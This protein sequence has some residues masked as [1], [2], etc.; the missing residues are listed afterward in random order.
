MAILAANSPLAGIRGRIE[1]VIFRSVNGRTIVSARPSVSRARLKDQSDR[2]RQTRSKFRNAARCAKIMMMDPVIKERYLRK[3]RELS[4]P[5]AYTAA[6][7]EYMQG[8]STTATGTERVAISH[9][10]NKNCT[11]TQKAGVDCYLYSKITQPVMRSLFTIPV[12]FTCIVLTTLHAYSQSCAIDRVPSSTTVPQAGGQT[13]Q[14][15][16]VRNGSCTPIF[17]VSDSWLTYT[18][19]SGF[20]R[21]TAAANP[22]PPRIGYVYVDNKESLKITINQAGS[23]VPVTGVT[24][25]PITAFLNTTELRSLTATVTPSNATNKTV[26]WTSDNSAIASVNYTTGVVTGVAAGTAVITART[27][28]ENRTATCTVTVSAMEKTFSWANRNGS[29]FTTPVKDQLTGGPCFLFAAVGAIEAKYKIV[30]NQPTS[31]IDLSEGQVNISCLGS[32]ESIP[33]AFTFSQNTG[34]VDEAC[35]PYARS[36]YGGGSSPFPNCTT[37]CANPQ[38]RI[39]ISGHTCIDFSTIA[40]NSRAD[41]LKNAIKQNGSVAVSFKSPSLHS[42]AM[43]AYEVYG[44][45]ENKWLMKDSWQ[46]QSANIQT[47]VNIPTIIATNESN[48]KACYI[49]GITSTNGRIASQAETSAEEQRFTET[50]LTLYPNPANTEITLGNFQPDNGLLELYKSDGSL[51][52]GCK[53]TGNKINITELPNG[54]YFVKV[55]QNKKIRMLKFIKL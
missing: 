29:N 49:T 50:D 25:S 37:P 53:I 43:H 17:T 31:N 10:M 13:F 20:L 34:I 16:I 2:Q 24:V 48:F 32:P 30:F 44:W 5:N 3:A 4:L 7:T 23:A 45:N 42:N 26:N 19:A 9:D 47:D 36:I 28:S 38:F 46:G 55:T 8:S 21:I 27:V 51:V 52:S 11:L 39:R 22:G 41:H 33:G 1:D 6:L 35:Y 14:F 40:V 54:L 18:Y 12:I 15:A